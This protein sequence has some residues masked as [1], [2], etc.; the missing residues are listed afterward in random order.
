MLKHFKPFR[1][2]LAVLAVMILTI[3][4]FLWETSLVAHPPVIAVHIGLGIILLLGYLQQVRQWLSS[5]PVVLTWLALSI[6]CLVVSSEF[7][8]G[9]LY[10]P[11][12]VISFIGL[13]IVW[14]ASVLLDRTTITQSTS[15]EEQAVV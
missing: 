9:E 10:T 6:V 4:G 2:T 15:R 1:F 11:T 8:H 5:T 3:V 14:R 12:A 13:G 7:N